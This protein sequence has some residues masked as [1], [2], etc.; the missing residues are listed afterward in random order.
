[1]PD[2]SWTPIRKGVF[3]CAPACGGKCTFAAYQRAKRDGAALAQALEYAKTEIG[4]KWTVRLWENKGWFYSV[5]RGA[6]E[7]HHSFGSS[8]CYGFTA[9]FHL[10]DPWGGNLAIHGDTPDSTVR[11]LMN[12][13]RKQMQPMADLCK[14]LEVRGQ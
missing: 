7:V 5:R 13:V 8:S 10:P 6:V 2:L 1:M 4:G 12:E 9:F 3:Y 14:L 11:L